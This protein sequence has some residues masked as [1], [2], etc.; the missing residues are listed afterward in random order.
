MRI[1][2]VLVLA[3]TV[4][5]AVTV[6][7]FVNVQARTGSEER[8][9]RDAGREAFSQPTKASFPPLRRNG[10]PMSSRAAEPPQSPAEV[11]KV[12][13]GMR[14]LFDRTTAYLEAGRPDLARRT[15]HRLK[16]QRESLPDFLQ[17][18]VDRLEVL[19]QSDGPLGPHQRALR[20]AILANSKH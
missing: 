8:A 3:A 12:V 10:A 20:A 9:I 17:I 16:A 7:D 18:Q 4:G 5:V 6:W 11:G 13:E 15:F 1:T 19:L 2:R 14:G